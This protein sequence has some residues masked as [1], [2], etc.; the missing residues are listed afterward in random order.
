MKGHQ[1]QQCNMAEIDL[2][3][4]LD[5]PRP[6]QAHSPEA[7]RALLTADSAEV[8]LWRFA[9]VTVRPLLRLMSA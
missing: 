7:T 8:R 6:A 2:H 9:D 3:S 4:A 5:T 1:G